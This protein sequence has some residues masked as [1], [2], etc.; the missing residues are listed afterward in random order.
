MLLSLKAGGIMIFAA[1][2]SYLGTFWYANKLEELEKLGRIK[3]L[4][5]DSFF[6]YDNM[7]QAIGRF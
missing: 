1:R 6:K 7:P 3:F 5:S 2:F 4:K